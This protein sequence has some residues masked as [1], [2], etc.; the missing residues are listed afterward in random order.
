MHFLLAIVG[1]GFERIHAIK[2]STIIDWDGKAMLAIFQKAGTY[3]V[4]EKKVPSL[5]CWKFQR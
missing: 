2:K 3:S 5:S 4:V 1:S